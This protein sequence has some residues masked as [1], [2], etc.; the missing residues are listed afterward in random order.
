MLTTGLLL[1]GCDDDDDDPPIIDPPQNLLAEQ[2]NAGEIALTWTDVSAIEDGYVV[3]RSESMDGSYIQIASLPADAT[4]YTDNTGL[5]PGT[6]YFYR[7]AATLNGVLSLYSNVASS[8]GGTA[9]VS[10]GSGDVGVLNYAYALEQL[11]AAFYTVVVDN[12]FFPGATDEEKRVLE[13]LRQHE[14]AHRDFFEAAIGTV[15]TPIPALQPDFSSVDFD[16]R[17][18]VLQT[19]K[20]FENLGVG[21]YNGAGKLL[22][23]TDYL[24]VA[25]KIVS[26]EARHAAAIQDLIN[27][28]AAFADVIDEG[29]DSAL[30]PSEVLAAADPFILTR[31]D[32]SNLPTA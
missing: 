20:T 26:V 12:N 7:V 13:D 24:L 4:S 5:V 15:G 18:S 11:E 17:D 16:N 19:A 25:G 23:N 28:D 21:A 1:T 30:E 3:E 6:E 8:M 22:E 14:V 29:L 10:L 27:P 32:A 2:N 9:L 31:I